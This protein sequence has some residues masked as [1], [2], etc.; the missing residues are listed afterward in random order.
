MSEMRKIARALGLSSPDYDA[1]LKRLG[2]EPTETEA[3]MF[4]AMWSEHCSYRSSKRFL[5]RFPSE[6]A[7]V[8][9]GP[10]ENAGAVSIG[11][12]QAV[13]FKMESH[14][15]P[16]MI[17]PYQ[18]AATGIGGIMR[19]IFTM[20]ARPVALLNALRFGA[21]DHP[22]TPHLLS[23][24][25][26]GIGDYGNCV[27]IP[28]VGGEVD[29][30]AAYNGNILVN[31]MCV[32]LADEKALFR[33]ILREGH[34]VYAIGARTGRDGLHG[35][36]MAS[37][38]FQNAEDAERAA[39]QIGDPFM[40]KLL[41]EA[42]LELM[43]RG[44]VAAAQDMGAAGL[45]SSAVEMAAKGGCGIRLNLDRLP[46]REDSMTAYEIML[47][48]SQE[49]ML[50]AAPPEKEKTIAEICDKW[51]IPCAQIG[52]ARKGDRIEITRHGECEANLPLSA[53]TRAPEREWPREPRRAPPPK[54]APSS[55]KRPSLD[56]TLIR[57]LATPALSSRRWVY[58]QYD[59]SVMGDTVEASGGDA[60]VIR[61]HQTR[62]ALAMVSE[63]TPAYLAAD[64]YLGAK[65]AV[66]EAWRNLNAVGAKPL[67]IT[68]CLNFGSPEE[69]AIM[70]QFAQSV[71]GLAEAAAYLDMPVV[72]GN[73]SFYNETDG[74]A[75]PPTPSVGAV[76]LIPDYGRRARAAF[77]REGDAI[78]LIGEEGGHL[79][80]SVFA[81]LFAESLPAEAPPIDL[82]KEKR[83]GLFLR[84]LIEEGRIVSAHDL[85]RGGLAIAL[86]E[87][88]IHGGIGAEIRAPETASDLHAFFFSED[89]AR[90]IFCAGSDS[91]SEMLKRAADAGVPALILGTTGGKG[92]TLR[93]A[94]PIELERLREAHESG[95]LKIMRRRPCR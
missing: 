37:A 56:E 40:Q 91:V 26:A 55:K 79:G 82:E 47:S 90:Y 33:A 22:K 29:F 2:R 88:A 87:M 8:L 6:G 4:G 7:H 54:H 36:V 38:S 30:D 42:S 21:A 17:D 53:L 15:H 18:G 12:G 80:C 35:A 83:H 81:D 92:L 94:K 75:I 71:E 23:G 25:V 43:A 51:D 48:E 49:R 63:A 52:E 45:T 9:Q 73:V 16:S 24:V 64:P 76:G 44:A 14:N 85:S 69:P 13:V 95:F 27:G 20:G 72:S 46:C 39:V 1:I 61:V 65:Q 28:T 84:A 50:L 31:A 67:A 3:G 11:D 93:G 19:D 59:S 34:K 68:D 70:E 57:M 32:G 74:R 89:Q 58:E 66:A 41:M 10:G 78:F 5:K 86:A 60:A 62:K 77:M